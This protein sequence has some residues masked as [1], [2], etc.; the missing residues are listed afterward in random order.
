MEDRIEIV[1]PNTRVAEGLIVTNLCACGHNSVLYA[2]EFWLASRDEQLAEQKRLAARPWW[3]KLRDSIMQAVDELSSM[4]A[5][6]LN[7]LM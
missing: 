2:T 3:E 4:S 1:P 6:G 7:K 5:A